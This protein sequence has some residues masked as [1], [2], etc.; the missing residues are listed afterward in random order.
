MDELKA[1]P[2]PRNAYAAFLIAFK[3]KSIK[4]VFDGKIS[5]QTGSG[6]DRVSPKKF[7]EDKHKNCTIIYRK[8]KKGTYRF[9]PYVE[10]LQ[11][12]GRDKAPRVISYPTVRDRI[13]LHVLKELLHHLFP[14]CVNRKLPNNFVKEVCEFAIREKEDNL[15]FFQTDISK[16]YDNIDH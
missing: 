6:I 4:E 13:V 8:C 5:T 12:K 10:L 16:F 3:L 15:H 2:T 9:S 14:D 7:A 11:S 1:S